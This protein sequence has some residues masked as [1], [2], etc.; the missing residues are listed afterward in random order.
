MNPVSGSLVLPS[1]FSQR[2]SSSVCGH[3]EDVAKFAGA[4]AV[5]AASTIGKSEVK[6]VK[7]IW[8]VW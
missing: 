6:S 5:G 2:D 3:C 4:D 8:S 7:D 1:H